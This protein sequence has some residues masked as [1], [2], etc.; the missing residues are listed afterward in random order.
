MNHIYI[1][2]DYSLKS[3]AIC[4]LKDKKYK[5]ISHPKKLEKKDLKRQEDVQCL[6]DVDLV[7]QND[8]LVEA[9]YSRNEFAKI[10]HYREQALAILDFITSNLTNSELKQSTIHIGFEGYSFGSQS[11][12]LID[13]I[14]ATTALKTLILEKDIFKKFTLDVYSP[15][16]IKKLAGYGSYDKADLF[17]VFIGEY[18]F[19]KEKYKERIE[20]DKK[21]N[22]RLDY[23]DEMLCGDFH[24]HCLNLELSRNVKKVKIPKPIDD[25]V[26]SYFI[27]RCLWESYPES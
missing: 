12:N 17:D 24:K 21:G 13:I 22:F 5:F 10:S 6:K 19:I 18:R 3:P 15:K 20:K 14:G 16:A 2:I 9:T 1:G 27:A 23:H 7:F 11:N 4:I 26:D 25:L 8:Q